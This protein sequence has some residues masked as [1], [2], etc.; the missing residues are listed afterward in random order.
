MKKHRTQGAPCAPITRTN[1]PDSCSM[2]RVAHPTSR[3][4]RSFSRE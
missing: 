4:R 2:V 1:K 3:R